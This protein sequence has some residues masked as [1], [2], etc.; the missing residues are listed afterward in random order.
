MDKAEPMV[1]S[2]EV[3]NVEWIDIAD[4]VEM[5]LTSKAQTLTPINRWQAEQFSRYGLTERDPMYVSHAFPRQR[6]HSDTHI[7]VCD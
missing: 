5:M 4:A 1:V 7:L 3:H 6:R 2:P